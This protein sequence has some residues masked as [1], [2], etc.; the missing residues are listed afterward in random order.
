MERISAYHKVGL[1]PRPGLPRMH[2]VVQTG[3]ISLA[4][5]LSPSAKR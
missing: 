3:V 1:S 4:I 5:L 2:F